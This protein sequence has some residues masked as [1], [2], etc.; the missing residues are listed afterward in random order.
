[1]EKERKESGKG[2]ALFPVQG[3]AH[4]QEKRKLRRVE[5]E[6]AVRVAKP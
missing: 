5:E 1:M 2:G 6:E 4:Q 3:K